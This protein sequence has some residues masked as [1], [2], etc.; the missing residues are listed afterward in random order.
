MKEFLGVTKAL[1]DRNPIDPEAEK[2][3]KEVQWAYETLKTLLERS[4]HRTATEEETRQ[5]E[6]TVRD[7]RRSQLMRLLADACP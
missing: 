4:R 2:K 1:S 6:Q 3:F 5:R 7:L